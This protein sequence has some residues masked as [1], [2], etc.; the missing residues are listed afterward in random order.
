MKIAFLS[1]N[2]SPRYALAMLRSARRAMPNVDALHLTDEDTP[3]IMGTI[4][5]RLPNTYDNLTIFRMH[6]L[7][8]LSGDTLCLDTDTIVRRSVRSIFDFQFDAALTYRTDKLVDVDG[9]DITKLMPYNTG[10]TFHR[11]PKF[12][13]AAFDLGHDKKAGWYTDQLAVAAVVRSNQ[14]NVLKLHCDNFNY[15]PNSATEDLSRRYIV[16][17]KGESRQYLDQLIQEGEL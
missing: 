6:H 16:H 7:A 2:E 9:N 10:V 14:F 15:K 17:Y 13:Q 11:D 12:W 8:Q 4:T 3:A 1:V 5:V